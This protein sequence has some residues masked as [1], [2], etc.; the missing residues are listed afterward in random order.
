MRRSLTLALPLFLLAGCG[1]SSSSSDSE[2]TNL[3][4][5]ADLTSQGTNLKQLNGGAKVTGTN[6]L[7]GTTT[8]NGHPASV[9][10][11]GNVAYTNGNGPFFGFLDITLENGSIL[12]MRMDGTATKNAAGVTSFDA[13]L[14]VIGG[15]ETYNGATGRGHFT[16]SRPAELGSP[17]RMEVQATLR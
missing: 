9:E 10:M 11:L 7:T 14:E 13:K 15:T 8:L 6:R 3:T 2:A 16:G 4:Y 17:L 1:G 12:S 5:T